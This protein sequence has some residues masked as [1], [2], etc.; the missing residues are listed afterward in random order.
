MPVL[1]VGADKCPDCKSVNIVQ[2][3]LGEYTFKCNNCGLCWYWYT[4]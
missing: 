1:P 2:G 4:D 3:D